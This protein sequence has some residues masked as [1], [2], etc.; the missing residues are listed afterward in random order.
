[1][2]YQAIKEYT[3]LP[4]TPI[5]VEQGEQ[6]T[7]TEQSDPLGD[8]PNWVYC[9]GHN[10]AGWVPKQILRLEDDIAFVE[11]DYFAHEHLLAVGDELLAQYELNGWIWCEHL[12]RGG[13]LGWAPLNHLKAM[14]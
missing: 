5:R 2:K 11:Q 3:D 4:E 1:M 10:K 7:W 8:W 13:E 14:P 9:Q 12:S 6:L